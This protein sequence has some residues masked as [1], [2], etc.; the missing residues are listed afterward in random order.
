MVIST[1]PSVYR[2]RWW[3][4]KDKSRFSNRILNRVGLRSQ[5]DVCRARSYAQILTSGSQC[6]CSICKMHCYRPCG[7]GDFN[8]TRKGI[9][10]SIL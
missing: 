7:S 9:T 4:S 2:I 10:K 1:K 5:M 3:R 6:I 8:R